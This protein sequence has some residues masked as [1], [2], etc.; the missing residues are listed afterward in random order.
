LAGA[1]RRRPARPTGI[2]A[3][4]G[5]DRTG[6]ALTV[7]IK[8]AERAIVYRPARPGVRA[9]FEREG[10]LG[11]VLVFPAIAILVAFIVYPFFVGLW[12]SVTDQTVGT[13][14][15]NFVGLQNFAE[16]LA[17]QIFRQTVGNTMLYTAVTVAFKLVLGL[18]LALLMNQH[19]RAKNLVRAAL[20]LPWIV[21]TALSTIAWKWLFDA[22]YSVVNWAMV[23]TGFAA[24][25]APTTIG[26]ALSIT[27]RG[28]NWLGNGSWAMVAIII[29]NI[30]RG[31]PFFA[32]SILAGLQTVDKELY[33]AA[34]ID[35]ANAWQRFWH[36]TLP[37]IQPVLLVVLLFSVIWT[38]ADFQLPFVLTGGGPANSTHLFG[39]LA[40]QEALMAGRLSAGA[41]I[42]LYM[43]PFLLAAV[44]AL[45]WYLRR[46]TV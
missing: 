33:E 16:Q 24:A 32:I 21:P 14:T 22:T 46:R 6:E 13:R 37:L 43:F 17:S 12:L 18:A 15:A 11:Y 36:I 26:Q 19:F 7:S 31:T 10:V 8:P 44:V 45:L 40:F 3:H 39:T 29:A 25:V 30:W 5:P 23:N 35:G 38:I 34:S 27:P 20:L 42:S 4:T 28:I 2:L 1:A 41:A 9:L